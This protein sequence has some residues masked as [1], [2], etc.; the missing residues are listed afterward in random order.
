[1]REGKRWPHLAH[2][3]TY[4]VDLMSIPLG[5]VIGTRAPM[6]AFNKQPLPR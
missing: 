3:G 6:E 4:V 2:S 1:M 5:A